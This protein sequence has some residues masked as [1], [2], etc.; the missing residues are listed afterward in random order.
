VSFTSIILLLCKSHFII[1]IRLYTYFNYIVDVLAPEIAQITFEVIF[2]Y[3]SIYYH[4]L[5]WLDKVLGQ[6]FKFYCDFP[7]FFYFFL[8]SSA[9]VYLWGDLLLLLLLLFSSYDERFYFIIYTHLIIMDHILLLYVHLYM[10]SHYN[11]LL[12]VYH[13]IF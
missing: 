13:F 3:W 12:L 8:T 5:C 11:S 6:N 10:I 9:I 2:I 1:I 7:H 4:T